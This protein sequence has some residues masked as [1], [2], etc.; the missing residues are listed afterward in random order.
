[1]AIQSL[2][3]WIA[4]AQQ[5]VYWYKKTTTVVAGF[6]YSMFDAPGNPGAGTLAIG[7]TANGLVPTPATDGYPHIESITNTGYM[8]SIAYNNYNAGIMALY[9]RLFAAG[10]Y[11]YNADTTLSSQPSYAGRVPNTNYNSLEIWIET[12]TGFTGTPSFQINYLDQDGNAGDTG[13]VAVGYPMTVGDTNSLPL[14]SGDCGVQRVDRVR[15]TGAS[16][17]TFN[18]S[19]HRSLWLGRINSVGD[20][21][22][23]DLL[24][25][26]MKQV[27]SDSALA[28]GPAADSTSTGNPYLEIEIADG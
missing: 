7:N 8:S 20:R 26:G 27:F 17:G 1:M 16:A 11:A 12:V 3:D 9:D 19:V 10:A 21:F 28:V 6:P 4:A 14:A 24:K 13:V 18:V 23:H 15:C 25:T 5:I 22:E 2:D